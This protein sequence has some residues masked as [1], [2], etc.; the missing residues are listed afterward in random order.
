[1]ADRNMWNGVGSLMNQR[2][3][4][5]ANGGPADKKAALARFWEEKSGYDYGGFLPTR[6]PSKGMDID[7]LSTD[8]KSGFDP[9][10]GI[11]G[12]LGRAVWA[13]KRVIEGEVSPMEGAWQ[14]GQGVTIGGMSS[15]LFPV[16]GP[17]MVAGMFAGKEAKTADLKKTCPG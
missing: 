4:E 9:A 14:A 7:E 2:M 13:P 16:K 5:L 8:R 10:G 1:M 11:L 6:T 3:L 15:R 17:G 12:I